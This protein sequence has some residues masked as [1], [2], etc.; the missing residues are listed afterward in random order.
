MHLVPSLLPDRVVTG[1]L[2][3]DLQP[4][5][6]HIAFYTGGALMDYV[7]ANK[8]YLKRR[9]SLPAGIFEQVTYV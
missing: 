5:I 6:V 9:C 7:H 4:T 2:G 8:A 1:Q 3:G